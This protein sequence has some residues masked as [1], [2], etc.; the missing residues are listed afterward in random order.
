MGEKTDWSDLADSDKP[1]IMHKG[2]DGKHRLEWR[3]YTRK[4][5]AKKLAEAYDAAADYAEKLEFLMNLYGLTQ[6]QLKTLMRLEREKNRPK[7]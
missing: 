4:E 7:P 3:D 5:L 1:I 2:P 6:E